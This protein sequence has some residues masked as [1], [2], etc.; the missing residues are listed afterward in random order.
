MIG[1]GALTRGL[2]TLLASVVLHAGAAALL[3][4]LPAREAPAPAVRVEVR[5]VEAP[6]PPKVLPPP[7]PPPPPKEA[8]IP[9][10]EPEVLEKVPDPVVPVRKPKRR[11]RPVKD[12]KPSPKPVDTKRPS[13]P[14]ER[15][16]PNANDDAEPVFGID[17][18]STSANGAGPAVRI[19]NTLQGGRRTGPTKPGK[20]KALRGS[21]PVAV[22][23]VTRMPLP[24]GRCSGRYTAAAREKGVEGTVELELVVGADGRGRDIRVIKGIG[25]GLDQAAIAA[26][27]R[28]RFKPGLRKGEKVAVRIRSFKIRFY[29]NDES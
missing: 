20:T 1:S 26:L 17:M 12:A 5:L 13:A 6:P 21:P 4:Q 25:F 28:C 10:V 19:G 3:E 23:E 16:D 14:T 24:M 27:K 22:D 29:L 9:E 2:V 7:P 15:P 11:V 18:N 8:A